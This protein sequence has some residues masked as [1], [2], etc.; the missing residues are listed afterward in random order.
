MTLPDWR[1]ADD[2]APLAKLTPAHWAWEFLRRNVAYREDYAWFITTWR[3]LEHDYGRP[4]HRDFHR[5]RQDPRAW[6]EAPGGEEP[7]EGEPLL[8]ECW[9][10]ERWGLGRFPPDPALPADQ[11]PD[12]PVWRELPSVVEE[13]PH[14]DN[15]ATAFHVSLRFD[16]RA[17]LEAQVEAARR[18]LAA[19]LHRLRREGR[20]EPATGAQQIRVL[21]AYLRL[22]DAIDEG[23]SPGEAMAL[24]GD[25]DAAL[26]ADADVMLVRA[27]ALRDAEYRFLAHS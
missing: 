16:T 4:P 24:L 2:Y 19:R 26:P 14:D 25:E 9:M 12:P 3:A 27:R 7:G 18:L 5:W 13:L 21:T 11:L 22:L 1:E 20:L 15:Q 17:P 23:A 6:R 8:I 10:G